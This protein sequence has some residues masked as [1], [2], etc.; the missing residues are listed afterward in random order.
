MPHSP[1]FTRPTIVPILLTPVIPRKLIV[2][3]PVMLTLLA[4]MPLLP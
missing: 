1:V 3:T 4:T 2:L